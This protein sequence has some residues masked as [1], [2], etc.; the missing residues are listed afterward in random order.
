MRTNELTDVRSIRN[1]NIHTYVYKYNIR[2]SVRR[3][4]LEWNEMDILKY[5]KRQR[6]AWHLQRLRGRTKWDWAE[7]RKSI[8]SLTWTRPV[9]IVLSKNTKKNK[10]KQKHSHTQGVWVNERDRCEVYE[11]VYFSIF[12]F[13]IC[14]GARKVFFNNK[15]RQYQWNTAEIHFI[16]SKRHATY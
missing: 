6:N 15:R 7:K 8:S 10:K 4:H 1:E 14:S 9:I 3:N 13:E 12:T 5:G 2:I 16:C 11:W